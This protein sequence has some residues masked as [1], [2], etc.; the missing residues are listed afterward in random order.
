MSLIVIVLC[1]S[2]EGLLIDMSQGNVYISLL[3]SHQEP[4]FRLRQAN[5]DQV[6]IAQR[7]LEHKHSNCSLPQRETQA[8]IRPSPAKDRRLSPFI[9]VRL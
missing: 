4:D 7:N 5:P 6:N 9:T 1:N 2:S 3:V 8:S